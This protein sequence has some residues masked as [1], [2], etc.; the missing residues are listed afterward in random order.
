MNRHATIFRTALALG[1]LA[2][3]GA[4]CVQPTRISAVAPGVANKPGPALTI[5]EPANG[6]STDQE[7]INVSGHTEPGCIVSVNGQKPTVQPDGTFTIPV[8]MC[9]GTNTIEVVA[10]KPNGGDTNIEVWVN[11]TNQNARGP[12]AAPS[13]AKDTTT[14]EVQQPTDFAWTDYNTGLARAAQEGKPVLI[15]FWGGT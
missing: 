4:G 1:L 14:V 8:S 5:S 9:N 6:S 13:A 12:A 11:C 10:T 15:D 7:V 3:A 2:L